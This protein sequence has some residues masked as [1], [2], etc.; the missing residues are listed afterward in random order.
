MPCRIYAGEVAQRF[1]QPVVVE[2]RTGGNNIIGVDAGR[3]G[4]GT[5]KPLHTAHSV[6]SPLPPNIPTP[7]EVGRCDFELPAGLSIWTKA[8]S[9]QAAVDKTNAAFNE[10]LEGQRLI[11]SIRDTGGVATGGPPQA[12][13]QKM[14]KD[15]AVWSEGARI[16]M[17][18]PQ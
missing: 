1:G 2:N 16:A 17:Y 10:A 5:V 8:G 7:K 14:E 6:R 15:F 3:N 4:P 12:L 13:H 9:P 18:E 11:D